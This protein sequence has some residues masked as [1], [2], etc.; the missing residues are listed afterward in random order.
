[1]AVAFIG[2]PRALAPVQMAVANSCHETPVGPVECHEV[3]AAGSV[4]PRGP[5]HET[6]ATRAIQEALFTLPRAR[7]LQV[8]TGSGQHKR[9]IAP[10]HLRT[11]LRAETE[12][13][14]WTL[15]LLRRYRAATAGCRAAPRPARRCRRATSRVTSKTSPCIARFVITARPSRPPSHV[16]AR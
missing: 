16:E 12:V 1:M 15:S 5:H 10:H 9:G 4:Q 3:L 8:S 2:S 13:Q 11:D 6:V 7:G 14:G